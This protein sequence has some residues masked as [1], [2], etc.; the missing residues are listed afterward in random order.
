V[1]AELF[2][3]DGWTDMTKKIVTLRNFANA[4]KYEVINEKVSIVVTS[5][6]QSVVSLFWGL[7]F[8]GPVNIG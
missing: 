4:P 1:E 7:N 8:P 6:I 3:A 2:H 5:P